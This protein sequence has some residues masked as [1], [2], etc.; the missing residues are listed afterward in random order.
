M[1]NAGST[2][3]K[4]MVKANCARASRTAVAPGMPTLVR[5]LER[6]SMP[7]GAPRSSRLAN[8]IGP[9]LNQA[10]HPDDLA[11]ISLDQVHDFGRHRLHRDLDV[12]CVARAMRP[13]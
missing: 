4:P 2:M 8:Q 12:H 9:H 6:G 13:H 7:S 10:A 3:W 11:Q 5:L 1:L